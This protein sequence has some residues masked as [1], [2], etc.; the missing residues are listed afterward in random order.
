MRDVVV[1]NHEDA[2]LKAQNEAYKAKQMSEHSAR[3]ARKT[4]EYRDEIFRLENEYNN[5]KSKADLLKSKISS[6]EAQAKREEAE[7]NSLRAEYQRIF[8]TRPHQR[9]MS[10]LLA[11]LPADR[12]AATKEKL[13]PR[14]KKNLPLV[15]RGKT[16]AERHNATLAE[17]QARD[18]LT[19]M[20]G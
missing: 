13:K 7:L 12:I 19:A 6:L 3:N 11:G 16:A 18:E 8:A 1:K 10:D 20:G 2:L 15:S 5:K 9:N 14:K 4:K 17:I